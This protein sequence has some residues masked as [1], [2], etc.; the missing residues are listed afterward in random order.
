MRK[1]LIDCSK[2]QGCRSCE[3]ACI[4]THSKDGNLLGVYADSVE[5]APRSR[6][7]VE[8]SAVRTAFPQFCRH[9]DQ[10]A[11]LEACP[12]GAIQKDAE[13][14]VIC[15]RDS[16]VACYM[17]VMSCPYGMARPAFERGGAM[18][19]CDGCVGKPHMACVS[20]CPSGCLTSPGNSDAAIEY[21]EKR[22]Q[23]L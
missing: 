1:K 14:N 23:T 21:V 3:I 9:C 15:D 10:P 19:K 11:C 13:G 20:A 4:A 16:C 5:A 7:R 8:L 12:V 22:A 17:C 18:F 2:C 6:N